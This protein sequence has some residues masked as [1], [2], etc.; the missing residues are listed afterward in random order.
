MV[1]CHANVSEKDSSSTLLFPK[2]WEKIKNH[3][4][5]SI[6]LTFLG[7]TERRVIK[8]NINGLMRIS[9]RASKTS[10]KFS[11]VTLTGHVWAAA[12]TIEARQGEAF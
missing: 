1:S 11:F 5:H 10:S 8:L 3:H 12:F 7:R 2:E 6:Q 9:L 4:C